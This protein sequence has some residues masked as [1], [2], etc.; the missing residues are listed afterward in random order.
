MAFED[1]L[2]VDAS[3]PGV[4]DY[5]LSATGIV[6]QTLSLWA[7]KLV[8]YIVIVGIAS[9]AITLVS[10]ILL[11]TIF[12]RIG[13]I[14]EDPI[15]YLF[16]IFSL[17]TLPDM[18]LIATTVGFGIIAFI[19]NAILSGAGIKFALDDYAGQNA[20]IGVSFSHA[21]GRIGRIIV[22]QL[23]MTIIVSIVTG[24]SIALMGSALEGIDISDPFNPI[25]TPEAIQQMM[26]A[27]M[28][29]FV[30][31]IF[32]VYITVRLVPALAI[33]MDTDLSAI[34]SLKKAWE[35]TSGN[36]F[37]VF[38]SQILIIL[39]VG[40]LGILVSFGVTAIMYLD[41][42]GIVIQTAI[43]ALFFSAPNLIFIAVIYRDLS[44]RHG[45]SGS[46]LPEY[47]L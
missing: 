16:G 1:G 32:I 44:S 46:D 43:S 6:S 41:P 30:G 11:L 9:V 28:L 40:I 7:R 8:Q 36:F 20:E 37:H 2:G 38:G 3:Q 22:I 19:I 21:F 47:V 26:M 17:S 23:I 42:L 14:S 27:S 34:D 33:V 18:T 39:A 4:E 45:I 35:M 10:F 29:L 31:G 13:V 25:I 5:T 15:T 12:G 24:P